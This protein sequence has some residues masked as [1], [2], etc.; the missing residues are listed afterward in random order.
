MTGLLDCYAAHKRKRKLSSGSEYDIAP[1]QIVTASQPAAE[2]GS[3]VQAI[4][5]PDS[6]ESGPTDQ[7]EPTGVAWL[8]SKEADL[9][10]SALQVTP[11]L[12]I[13]LRVNL[14]GQSLCGSS[15]RGPHFRTRL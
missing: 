4:I 14:A 11:P 15:C 6:P 8:E 13:G 1:A 5:I 2:G 3:K 12:P 7:T 10:P 9:V